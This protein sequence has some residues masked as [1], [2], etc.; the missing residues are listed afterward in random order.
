MTKEIIEDSNELPEDVKILAYIRVWMINNV[1]SLNKIFNDEI[2]KEEI[3][4]ILKAIK[5]ID[6]LIYERMPKEQNCGE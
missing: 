5:F 6:K 4:N 3:A 2:V 1:V